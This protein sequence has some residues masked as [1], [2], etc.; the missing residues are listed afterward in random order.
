MSN[1][2]QELAW[3]EAQEEAVLR[4]WTKLSRYGKG[5][6]RFLRTG[7]LDQYDFLVLAKS[8]LPLCFVEVKVRRVKFGLYGDVLAPWSK[9][10]F[11]RAASK[12]QLPF[13][14]VTEYACNALVEV[15]LTVQPASRRNVARRDRP[16][17]API[18]HGLYAGDQLVVLAG[19]SE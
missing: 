12:H 11:A 7:E 15:D 2:R 3:G 17:T 8:G 13:L 6:A 10:T 9:H 1:V 4:R 18:P 19:A 5:A 16:G 14:L